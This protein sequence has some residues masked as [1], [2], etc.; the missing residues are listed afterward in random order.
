MSLIKVGAKLCRKVVR[1][2]RSRLMEAL[3]KTASK[4][5]LLK[6]LALATTS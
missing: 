5:C 2:T 6:S 3:L 1:Y 4:L